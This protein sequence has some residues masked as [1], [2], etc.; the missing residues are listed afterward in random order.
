MDTDTQTRSLFLW[1]NDE[2][3]LNITMDLLSNKLEARLLSIYYRAPAIFEYIGKIRP[4]L[5][6]P[7]CKRLRKRQDVAEENI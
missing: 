6:V 2:E 1:G 5:H 4:I 3:A 7:A